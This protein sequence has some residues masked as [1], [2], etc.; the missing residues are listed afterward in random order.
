MSLG[1][2]RPTQEKMSQEKKKHFQVE[3]KKTFSLGNSWL[4]SLGSYTQEKKNFL[5]GHD[6]CTLYYHWLN[7]SFPLHLYSLKAIFIFYM[8]LRWTRQIWMTNWFCWFFGVDSWRKIWRK[9]QGWQ[10]D[11]EAKLAGKDSLPIY[12]QVSVMTTLVLLWSSNG[13]LWS[14]NFAW[15]DVLM[16]HDFVATKLT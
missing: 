8:V 7:H 6:L 3:K 2:M 4:Y 10:Q 16:A 12:L 11:A 5:F 13:L 14:L 1:C 9:S 15:I